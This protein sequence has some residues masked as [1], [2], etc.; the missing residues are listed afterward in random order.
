MKDAA[1][2]LQY[3]GIGAFGGSRRT[4]PDSR[5]FSSV[6]SSDLLCNGQVLFVSTTEGRANPIGKLVSPEQPLG[7]D[8]LAFAVDPLGLYGVE[9][10]TLG[11]Q[12]D[13]HYPYPTAAGFDTAVVSGDPLSHPMALVPTSVV[14]DEKQSFLAPPVELLATPPEEPCGHVANR[15][16][17]HEPQPGLFELRQVQPVAGEGLRLGIVLRGFFLEEAHRGLRD[18]GPRTQRRPLEAGEPAL[19]LEAQSPLGVAPGEPDQPISSP[20]LRAYCGSGLSIQRLARSQ[21]TPS[22]ASVARM[23]SPLT[24]LC[25]MPSSKL[26][27][28]RPSVRSTGCFV[29][30]TSWGCGGA[31]RLK[32]P[33]PS[34]RR[35]RG[36]LWDARSPLG[37]RRGPSRRRHGW[38]CA[39]S[40]SRTRDFRRSEADALG[41]HWRE[42]SGSA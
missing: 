24:G 19:V 32:P 10:R 14:P 42:G 21:R 16:A 41:G 40:G 5:D 22:L 9:P 1:A 34:R 15:P 29:C 8:Y 13:R 17:V 28:R 31:S 36:L 6:R 7:L 27:S 18:I 35:R 20:F 39:P 11:G 37:G 25:V 3:V 30:R 12:Q 26:T 4:E 23:V 33:I 2:N 38:R